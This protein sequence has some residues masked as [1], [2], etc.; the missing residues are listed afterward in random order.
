M[1]AH[2][3]VPL[4]HLACLI[5]E[6]IW[7]L[8]NQT[9]PHRR[10][11]IPCDAALRSIIGNIEKR[12]EVKLL[13]AKPAP[14]CMHQYILK[15]PKIDRAISTDNNSNSVLP[16]PPRYPSQPAYAAATSNGMPVPVHETNNILKHPEGPEFQFQVGEGEHAQ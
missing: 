10:G 9:A 2:H 3:I 1:F 5:P 7:Q 12:F 16:P 15:T 14:C 4:H 8:R 11:Q 6:R 13:H